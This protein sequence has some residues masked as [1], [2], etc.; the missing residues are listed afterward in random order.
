MRFSAFLLTTLVW[1]GT[2][3]TIKL[4]PVAFEK[5]A[6]VTGVRLLNGAHVQTLAGSQ[7]SL[8][9]VGGDQADAA[10]KV[11][12]V[13]G[14]GSTWDAHLGE[15]GNL[16]AVYTQ[17]GSAVSWIMLRKMEEA[18]GT[19][20]NADA[21]AVYV[22]PHFVK[23]P[24]LQVTAIRLA[25][26][27]AQVMMLSPSSAPVGEE[28]GSITDARLLVVADGYWLFTLSRVPGV[29]G[30]AAPRETVSGKQ[31][32][33]ILQVTQLGED[34]KPL[35]KPVPVFGPRPVYEF[36]VDVAPDHEVAVLAT[37]PSGLIYARSALK[38]TPVPEKLIT[39]TPFD[40]PLSSPSLVVHDGK[41]ICAVIE[42]LGTPEARILKGQVE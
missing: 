30:D 22:R 13:G 14:P 7:G 19:R 39:E 15:D 2:N 36:D 23:G 32:P 38:E 25:D 1:I 35:G 21:F 42:N 34:L 37:T 6:S 27:K 16:T 31:M 17:P 29:G 10:T 24:K 9:W 28:Q 11:L 41:P 40:H 26:G 8:M 5:P 3:M 18:K 12:Q 4:Q 20:L 33:G